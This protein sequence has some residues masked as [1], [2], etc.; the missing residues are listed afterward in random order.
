MFR[1]KKSPN[2]Q[3]AHPSEPPR[4]IVSHTDSTFSDQ[5]VAALCERIRVVMAGAD[6]WRF[7]WILVRTGRA[8]RTPIDFDPADAAAMAAALRHTAT[9]PHLYIPASVEFALVLA[10]AAQRA[11]DAGESW[12]WR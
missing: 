6:S 11:A 3:A 2:R 8:K 5:A 7:E 4:W 10:A 12:I 1:K 9:A